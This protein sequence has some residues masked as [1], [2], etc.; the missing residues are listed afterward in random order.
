[1]GLI[2]EFGKVVDS[3]FLVLF[4][5]VAVTQNSA[6]LGIFEEFL[7]V[8]LVSFRLAMISLIT[9]RDWYCEGLKNHVEM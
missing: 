3:N 1:M 7:E 4:R 8:D 6:T 2:I 5:I 9:E